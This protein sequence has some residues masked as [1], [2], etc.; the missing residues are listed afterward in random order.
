MI[1]LRFFFEADFFFLD[2]TLSLDLHALLKDC[3]S[4]ILTKVTA[5]D[6]PYVVVPLLQ[7]GTLVLDASDMIEC[8]FTFLPSGFRSSILPNL[9]LVHALVARSHTFTFGERPLKSTASPVAP[10]APSDSGAGGRH[11]LSA[12][13][14]VVAACSSPNHAQDIHT[15]P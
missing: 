10:V 1:D 9:M 2:P 5:L 12:A 3:T 15:Y 8:A 11:S 13:G 4:S 14:L 7:V 6:E